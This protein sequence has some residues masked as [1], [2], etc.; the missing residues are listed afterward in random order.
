M[1]IEAKK[2]TTISFMCGD[3]KGKILHSIEESIATAFVLVPKAVAIRETIREAIVLKMDDLI[4]KSNSQ[5][6]INLILGKTISSSSIS[7]LVFDTITLA[8]NFRHIQFSY[9]NRAANK[10]ENM[11]AKKAHCT[12]NGFVSFY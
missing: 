11:L 5:T 10:V 2:S 4:I 12:I 3:D 8:Q 1:R 6:V 9:C 7:N